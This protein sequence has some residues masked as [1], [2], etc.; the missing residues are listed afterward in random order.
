MSLS[1][2]ETSPSPASPFPSPPFLPGLRTLPLCSFVAFLSFSLPSTLFTATF[3]VYRDSSSPRSLCI[4]L[5]VFLSFSS[6]PPSFPSLSVPVHHGSGCAT[7]ARA[8]L[9]ARINSCDF[10]P[11]PGRLLYVKSYYR[12]RRCGTAES[13]MRPAGRVYRLYRTGIRVYE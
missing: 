6:L 8:S 9:T 4:S 1:P 10:W 5:S 3:L 13:R 12:E 2:S 11:L 7:T